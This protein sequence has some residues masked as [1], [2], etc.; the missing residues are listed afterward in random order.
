ME[1]TKDQEIEILQYCRQHGHKATRRR[2]NGLTN[3]MI[4]K[5]NATHNILEIKKRNG[6]PRT[7]KED[8][9]NDALTIGTYAAARKHGIAISTL[10]KWDKEL[11]ILST[12]V[13]T[14]H[15]GKPCYDGYPAD[16]IKEMLEH[17]NQHGISATVVKYGVPR[18]RLRQWNEKFKIYKP[19]LKRIFVTEQKY[20]IIDAY[21]KYGADAVEYAYGVTPNLITLWRHQLGLAVRPQRKYTPKQKKAA[22][23]LYISD[24][25]TAV[26]REY[27]IAFMVVRRWYLDMVKQGLIAPSR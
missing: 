16:K 22:V 2:Y 27:G 8:A 18:S 11:K 19:K 24:G 4:N 26:E 23:Q 17:A 15:A 6:V 1:Y 5:M 14:F 9:L 13:R 21:D 12:S 7:K 10:Y 3:Y 25:P 20:V